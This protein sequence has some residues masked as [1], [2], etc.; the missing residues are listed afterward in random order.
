MKLGEANAQVLHRV[1]VARERGEFQVGRAGHRG[2][3]F[4]GLRHLPLAFRAIHLRE[5]EFRQ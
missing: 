4:P 5:R 3:D 1:G 2:P